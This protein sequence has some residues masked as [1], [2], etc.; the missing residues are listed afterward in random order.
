[1]GQTAIKETKKLEKIT[2]KSQ[3]MTKN[4]FKKL[5]KREGIYMYI[6]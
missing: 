1:M 6:K 5:K 2:K 4:S 3:K